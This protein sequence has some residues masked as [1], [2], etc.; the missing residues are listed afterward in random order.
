MRLGLPPAFLTVSWVDLPLEGI[1]IQ[2][3]D[4]S[5]KVRPEPVESK[6]SF[7]HFLNGF[8]LGPF[9]DHDSIDCA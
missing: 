9:A 4:E 3:F 6:P 2:I 1:D 7:S 5:D 8:F